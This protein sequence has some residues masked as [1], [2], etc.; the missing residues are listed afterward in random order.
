MHPLGPDQ[1]T[2]GGLLFRFPQ[3]SA[4]RATRSGSCSIAVVLMFGLMILPLPSELTAYGVSERW[5]DSTAL[6]TVL[7]ATKTA[8]LAWGEADPWRRRFGQRQTAAIMS[9]H[10]P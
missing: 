8:T 2:S 10:Q 4:S 6:W 9:P 7:G 3:R 1:T 5:N